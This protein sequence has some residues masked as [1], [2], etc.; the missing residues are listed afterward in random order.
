MT[1]ERCAWVSKDE[2]YQQYHDEVWGK[3]VFDSQALFAK[4]CLDGQQA[5]LSWI[6]I[7]KKQENYEAAF[8]DFNPQLISRMN[9]EHVDKL[10]F[11]SGIVRNR[12]KIQSI[13]NNAKAYSLMEDEGINFSQFLWQFIGGKT[14]YNHWPNKHAV[15]TKTIES[16]AMSKA[17]KKR[18]FSFVGSTIC[19]A[20]MQAVGMVNDHT[21]NCFCYQPK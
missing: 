16:D 18:G 13:I 1:I 6:T 3:P 4:L 15:P 19:Y 21:Q 11:N 2:L 5:G 7:L 8:F 20:F 9:K 14:R 17:L 12:L 10:M